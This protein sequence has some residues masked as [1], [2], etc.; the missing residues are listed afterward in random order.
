MGVI[1]LV[2]P[3]CSSRTFQISAGDEVTITDPEGSQGVGD[4]RCS[5]VRACFFGARGVPLARDG[6]ICLCG[7]SIGVRAEW[8]TWKGG[9]GGR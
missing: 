5:R 2:V 9:S 3:G 1:D 6:A 7:G 4:F 8:A